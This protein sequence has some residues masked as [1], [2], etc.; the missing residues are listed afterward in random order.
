[1]IESDRS[2]P[3]ADA[4][5]DSWDTEA[6]QIVADQADALLRLDYYRTVGDIRTRV[7][8]PAD[9]YRE[10]LDRAVRRG[11]LPSPTALRDFVSQN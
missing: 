11:V 5:M 9:V 6:W 2:P 8:I 7:R 4:I 3:T 1:M 10:L